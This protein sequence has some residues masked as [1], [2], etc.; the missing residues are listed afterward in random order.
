M[1]TYSKQRLPLGLAVG[2]LFVTATVFVPGASEPATSPMRLLGIVTTAY[3]TAWVAALITRKHGRIQTAGRFVLCSCSIL[4]A[5]GLFELPALLGLVDYRALFQTRAAPWERPGNR[6]DPI[7]LYTREGGQRLRPILTG[8]DVARLKGGPTPALYACDVSHDRDG[9]RNPRDLE[10]AD[11]VV[12]GDSL[13]EGFHIG[14]REIVTARLAERSG[15]VVANLARGGDGPQQELEV[16]RRYGLRLGPRVCVWSFY[17]GNDLADAAEYEANQ[18]RVAAWSRRPRWQGLLDHSFT[19]NCLE[20]LIRTAIHPEPRAPARLFTGRFASSAGRAVD[21]AFGSGDYRGRDAGAA[22]SGFEKLEAVLTGARTLCRDRRIAIVFV[23]IPSKFRVY[24]DCCE[25]QADSPCRR[26]PLDELP[27]AMRRLVENLGPEVT[28]LDL[29]E[30]FRDE[31]AAGAL[32][33][34]PDDTHWT[35]DGHRLAAEELASVLS[36]LRCGESS[37]AQQGP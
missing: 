29:S 12:L 32:V 30:R 28:F 25:F 26:W 1:R 5:V 24:R 33:Y 20:F 3:L 36:S 34:L 27:A 6:P 37:T 14:E 31:A 35:S 22:S 23:F 13:V 15:L 7:L 21:L 16:L 2:V 18:E 9:F 10:A 19:R 4:L 17:E 8:N 11:V